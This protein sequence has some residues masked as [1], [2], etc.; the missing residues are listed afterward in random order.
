[1]PICM[2]LAHSTEELDSVFRLRHLV[3]VE[4]EKILQGNSEKRLYDRFDAFPSSVQML[5]EHNGQT[6][7]AFRFSL[8]DTCGLPADDYFDFRPFVPKNARL[9]HSGMFCVHKDYRGEKIAMGLILMAAYYAMSNNITHVVAPINPT[10][11]PLLRRIG[12]KKVGEQFH[13]PHLDYQV[14]PLLMDMADIKDFFVE[15]IRQN[16]LHDFIMDYQRWFCKAGE[17]IVKAGD[18]GTEAFII[19]DGS[20]EV[21]LPGKNSVLATLEPGEM[22]GEL[23][24]ITG[25][26]RSADVVAKS[27]LQMMVMT[28]EIFLKRFVEDSNKALALMRMISK[29]SQSMIMNLKYGH[30]ARDETGSLE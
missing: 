6:V 27:E 28:K 17:T 4:Q 8:D 11:A 10:I 23:A 24:L 20:A 19:I 25:E 7:G 16:K 5:A 3:F 15:F 30:L 13:D 22:F 2:R 14:L 9:M 26:C 29:R 1:M 18:D 12:F 21:R